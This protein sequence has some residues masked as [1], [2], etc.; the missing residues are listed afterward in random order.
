MADDCCMKT[1][2]LSAAISFLYARMPMTM[3]KTAAMSNANRCPTGRLSSWF[4]LLCGSADIAP[5]L[6]GL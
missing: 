6:V 4:Q 3:K 2:K 1:F 5:F